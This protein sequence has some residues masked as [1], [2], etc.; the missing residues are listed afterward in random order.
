[1]HPLF[2]YYME[3]G[4]NRQYDGGN[5]LGNYIAPVIID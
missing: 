3:T 1:M 2:F 4:A 5:L